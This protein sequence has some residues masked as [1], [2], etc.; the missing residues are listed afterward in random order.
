V[1]LLSFQDPV[2]FSG[3]VRSNL[4]PFELY[5][6]DEIWVAL[7]QSYLKRFVQSVD[8]GLEYDCG[9]GGEALR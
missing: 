4:D 2:V 1:I 9:E 7:E 8:E 3:S 5:T 6:D